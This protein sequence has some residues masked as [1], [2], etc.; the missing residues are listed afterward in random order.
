MRLAG[1]RTV[2]AVRT[3]PAPGEYLCGLTWDG[4]RLWHSDQKALHIYALERSDGCVVRQFPCPSVRADLAFDGAHLCQIGGRPKRLVL[5]DRDTGATVGT[6][7]IDPPSGR[8]TGVELAPEGLWLL[9]R[10][11]TVVQLRDYPAMTVRREHPVPG[12][13][14]SGLTVADGIIACGDFEAG[15]VH[16]LDARTG[17]F[18]GCARLEGRP[19][20]MTWD[21]ECLWYCDFQAGALRA[22]DFD[23]VLP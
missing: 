1:D 5:I 19:T 22:V 18:L 10:G 15:L 11:P 2:A 16:A 17:R 6:R 8:V 13:S 14:P 12:E 4:A 20:G 23:D 3:L 7:P 9:L 21:G